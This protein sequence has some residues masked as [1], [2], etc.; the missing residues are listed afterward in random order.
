MNR[1]FR[2]VSYKF[3][4]LLAKNSGVA[5]VLF[6]WWLVTFI[7]I[8]DPMLL[9]GP[10]NTFISLF[11]NL[12]GGDLFKDFLFTTYRTL[13]SFLIAILLGIPLGLVIGVKREIYNSFEFL[14]DFFRSTPA[15]ALFPLFLVIFGVGDLSRIAVAS[16]A[17]FLIILFNVAYGV[18]NVE[19][20]RVQAARVMGAPKWRIFLDV[21]FF[22][23]LPQTFVG[24]RTSLSLTLVVIIIAEMFIG[25][26]N[27]LGH[28]ITDAQQA[29]DMTKMYASIIA[30]GIMGYVLNYIL[31]KL[32]HKFIHWKT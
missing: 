29:Y 28:R 14:I 15:T 7:D 11:T 30:T 19:K 1:A 25:A 21:I 27:G 4:Y 9:P 18:L 10:V 24:L 2:K 12:F 26:T 32:E 20:T 31:L 23:T 22:E 8:I 6:L 5:S 3:L 13:F 16:F 17:S